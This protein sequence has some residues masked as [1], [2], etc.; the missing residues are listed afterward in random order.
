MIINPG[1]GQASQ[2]MGFS[3]VGADGALETHPTKEE[4]KNG[5]RSRDGI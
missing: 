3:G 1:Q 5:E 2:Q 4:A